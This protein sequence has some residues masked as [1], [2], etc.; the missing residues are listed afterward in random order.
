MLLENISISDK[1]CLSKDEAL[2]EVRNI[3]DGVILTI[4]A[5]DIDQL[6]P[7]IRTAFHV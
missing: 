7:K 6:V 5:G 4:G 3:K 1:K 2:E